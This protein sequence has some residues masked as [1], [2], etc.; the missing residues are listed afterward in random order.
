MKVLIV[1]I[2][3][4]LSFVSTAT[5]QKS[6]FPSN[7]N[8]KKSNPEIESRAIEINQMANEVLGAKEN[9]KFSYHRGNYFIFGDEELKIQFSAKYRFAKDFNL[10]AGYTQLMF[11]N[12]YDDSMPFGE[13]NYNPEIFYR[14]VEQKSKY[15][16]SIDIGFLHTSNGEDGEISRSINRAIIKANGVKKFDRFNI[17]TSLQLQY[18]VE[19]DKYSKNIHDHIG[20]W[21]LT[22]IITH[23]ITHNKQHLDL[24]LRLFAGKKGYDL[25]Q[26]GRSIGLI[27]NFE[28]ENFNPNIYLQ[29]YSGYA[30]SLL[31]Q[32]KKEDNIRL[33]LTLIL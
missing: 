28:S 24:E 29:Y 16:R 21:D 6:D 14:I 4:F 7:I 30:E 15:I 3:L 13:I 8:T 27:Y 10:Y 20:Y 12:I 23:L 2:F 32:N 1:N 5:A 22:T 19:K 26:G 33:G 18:V 31:K 9:E 25:D 11:W 17:I